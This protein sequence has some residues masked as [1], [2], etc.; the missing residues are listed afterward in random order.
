MGVFGL[1]NFHS[2]SPPAQAGDVNPF[3]LWIPRMSR[4]MMFV[5]LACVLSSSPAHAALNIPITVNLSESVNVT[6][7]PQ[8][9]VDVGGTT[10]YATYTSGTGT[11]ALTFTLAPQAGD[12]DLDGVTVASP[13]QLNGGTIKDTKGNNATLT[14][15]PPNTANVKVNYPSLGMDFVY[16]A[17][18]RYTLNGTAYNDLPSF[19]TATG[20]SFTRASIGTYFDSAGVMQTAASGAPRFD[21]APV[22]HAAKGILIE[23]SRTNLAKNSENISAWNNNTSLTIT[24]DAVTAPNGT[25]TADTTNSVG[26]TRYMSASV[27]SG[28]QYTYSFFVKPTDITRQIYLYV[29]GTA[30]AGS[31]RIV[32]STGAIS[33]TSGTYNSAGLISVGNGWYRLYM[34]FTPTT[35]GNQAVHIYPLNSN[36]T[37]WWGAQL[38]AGA[39]PTSYIPTTTA[40][41]TR[42]ADALNLPTGSWHTSGAG[43]LYGQ[44]IYDMTG[45]TVSRGM[46]YLDDGSPNNAAGMYLGDNLSPRKMGLQVMNGGAGQ[47]SA[48]SG[49]YTAG[50]L[51][52]GAM[53]YQTDDVIAAFDGT[54]TTADT[55]AIIPPYSRFIVGNLRGYWGNMTGH[56]QKARYYPTRVT[57]T[58][59]QLLTQ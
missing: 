51:I 12:V 41:V 9:A 25:M 35:T 4:V 21:Y 49:T 29:D 17:D 23:E 58:Q 45:S 34:V 7:T 14:F 37:A 59:L 3:F 36:V 16:D 32:P 18:G 1:L 48:Y 47:A 57:D 20:G 50:N 22:T 56:V 55:S 6:G 10:R 52:K 2:F 13:I 11:N 19:L 38:E 53:A 30:G 15:T 26:S 33:N 31:C 5:A 44:G 8:I 40:A 42:A 46:V 24:S 54:L 27:T 39:F 28:A 43:T